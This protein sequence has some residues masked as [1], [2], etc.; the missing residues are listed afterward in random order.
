MKL[1]IIIVY[2]FICCA[3]NY[4]EPLSIIT[5][6]NYSII[7]FMSIKE[8]ANKSEFNKNISGCP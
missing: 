3:L 6:I 8:F 2:P 4:F 1:F 7:E 5:L